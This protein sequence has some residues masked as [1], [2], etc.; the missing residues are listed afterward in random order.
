MEKNPAMPF[1]VALRAFGA[2]AAPPP[3]D[4]GDC[5]TFSTCTSSSE[6]AE[7][8][9]LELELTRSAYYAARLFETPD[10]VEDRGLVV[11]VVRRGMLVF[12]RSACLL[13]CFFS[14]FRKSFFF[15]FIR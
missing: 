6:L 12:W 13:L 2:A 10:I 15:Y 1:W 4:A 14:F 9:E 8:S 11:A 7:L 5:R 3:P